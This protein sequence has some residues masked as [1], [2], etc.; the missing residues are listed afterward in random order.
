METKDDLKIN[1]LQNLMIFNVAS[2]KLA[3]PVDF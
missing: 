1:N 3:E 2:M